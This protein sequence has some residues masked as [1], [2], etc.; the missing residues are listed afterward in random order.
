MN[1]LMRRDK[2]PV[3]R[4]LGRHACLLLFPYP[5]MLKTSFFL[6][7]STIKFMFECS[8]LSSNFLKHGHACRH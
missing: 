7:F 4:S 1:R 5:W 8:D 2:N 6:V 3:S